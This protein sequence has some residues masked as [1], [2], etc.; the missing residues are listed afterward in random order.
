MRTPRAR[1][2]RRRDVG[3]GGFGRPRGASD[4]SRG[5]PTSW[6]VVHGSRYVGTLVTAARESCPLGRPIV[7]VEL[8]RVVLVGIPGVGWGMGVETSIV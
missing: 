2:Y 8:W 1:A 7:T 4:R 6:T 5:R 3:P